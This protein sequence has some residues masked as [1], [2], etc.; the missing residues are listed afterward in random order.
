MD[1]Y[2]CLEVDQASKMAKIKL[3]LDTR[4]SLKNA[5]SELFPIVLRVFHN[6]PRIIRL[7][8]ELQNVDVI[9]NFFL[10][11]LMVLSK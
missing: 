8:Y 1:F 9:P 11:Q 5:I 6:K 10:F 3:I 4:K 7:P 2:Y